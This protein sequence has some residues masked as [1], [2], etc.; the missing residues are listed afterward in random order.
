MRNLLKSKK[1]FTLVEIVIVIAII[2]ILAM[3][4]I[5][6]VADTLK[7]RRLQA[8]TEKAR[9]VANLMVSGIES[10]QIP[11]NE[12]QKT[13]LGITD[14]NL[15]TSFTTEADITGVSGI[16]K[17]YNNPS[18]NADLKDPMSRDV[19]VFKIKYNSSEKTISIYGADPEGSGDKQLYV[20]TSPLTIFDS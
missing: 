12:S 5:P 13:K 14:G 10:G 11:T 9:S 2:G 16:E 18:E 17:M 6:A 4:L 20:T 3:T 1:G 8:A 7:S 19:K 15:I